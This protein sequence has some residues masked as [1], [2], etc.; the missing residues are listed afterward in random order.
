MIPLAQALHRIRSIATNLERLLQLSRREDVIEVNLTDKNK[1]YRK[2]VEKAPAL[3]LAKK[4]SKRESLVTLEVLRELFPHL[5]ALVT[6]PEI[7]PHMRCETD[8]NS[9]QV[10]VVCSKK[11]GAS[12]SHVN[13]WT[14]LRDQQETGDE[15]GS[16]ELMVLCGF[17]Y[18]LAWW[19]RG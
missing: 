6:D 12:S 3:F 5:K 7:K 9:R 1:A 4:D 18:I 15:R 14:T 13:R 17:H 19:Q 8:R 10:T 16:T 2:A 11:N